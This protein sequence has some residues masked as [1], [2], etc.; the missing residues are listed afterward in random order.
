MR[1]Q[2]LPTFASIT[3]ARSRPSGEREEPRDARVVGA[4]VV[5]EDAGNGSRSD[6]LADVDV[7]P[8]TSSTAVVLES[9]DGLAGTR[10]SMQVCDGQPC[11][12]DVR[13]LL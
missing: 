6:A 10:Q 4:E 11:D 3:S 12:T 13:M 7:E 2:V 5:D 9:G 8:S 1:G